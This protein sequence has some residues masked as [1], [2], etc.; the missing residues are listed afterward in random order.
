[1][2]SI[3]KINP[4]LFVGP[5]FSNSLNTRLVTLFFLLSRLSAKEEKLRKRFEYL[6]SSSI[7]YYY[8]YASEHKYTN[9]YYRDSVDRLVLIKS[10]GL[11]N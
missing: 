7:Y 11:I 3:D 8:V 6:K 4:F 9:R 5:T 2:E 1:M 10:D